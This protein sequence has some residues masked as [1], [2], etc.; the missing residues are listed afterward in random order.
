MQMT[1]RSSSKMQDLVSW[2]V[3]SQI[4]SNFRYVNTTAG[5]NVCV[6]RVEKEEMMEREGM[7]LH[8]PEG[9]GLFC[10]VS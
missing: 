3:L 8:V 7:S 5:T 1:Q 10:R 4:D 6:M 9:A 2:A